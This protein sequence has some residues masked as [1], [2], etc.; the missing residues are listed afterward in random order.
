[1][2]WILVFLFL[3]LIPL[4]VL[5]RNYNNFKRSCIYSSI[6][7]VLVSTIVITNM[8]MSGLNKIR[9]AMYYQ[10]YA[11]D[12]R[13]KD[14]YASNFE[15]DYE[16]QD[17]E[18]KKE[19][20]TSNVEI[21]NKS[22]N[23]NEVAKNNDKSD[24]KVKEDNDLSKNDKIEEVSIT[25]EKTDK[26]IVTEFKKEIYDIETVA[27]VPMRDCMPYT[28]N[29]SENLKHLDS[30]EEDVEYAQKMCK[31]V[32]S[33]YDDMNIPSLS[34]KDYTQVLYNARDDVKKAYELREKAMES[35]SKLIETKNPK[36]IGKIT[37]YLK[38]SDKHITSFK[39]RLSDLNDKM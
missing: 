28:K 25:K 37:E 5:F 6:Y 23:E 12:E 9:E 16:E 15:K 20:T 10:N 17:K 30:I 18:N 11:F 36:Y 26:E 2:R 35:A 29:I 24:N 31:E 19:K 32:I 33:M 13:Y 22:S 27:L 4:I 14:K 7:I 1:M 34:E 21:D 3:Y 8:Y 38:L 39:E